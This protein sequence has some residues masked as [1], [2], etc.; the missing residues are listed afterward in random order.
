MESV[1]HSP[2][3]GVLFLFFSFPSAHS[4]TRTVFK[5]YPSY[6]D[7]PSDV[8]IALLGANTPPVSDTGA[9]RLSVALRSLLIDA[10]AICNVKY[11]DAS[12]KKF[13]AKSNEM[14]LFM[15][16][17]F[18]APTWEGEGCEKTAELTDAGQVVHRNPDAIMGKAGII[19]YSDCSS[20]VGHWD[21]WDGA[22]DRGM[23]LVRQCRTK[24]VWNVC[25]QV[26]NPD[27]SALRRFMHKS[28]AWDASSEPLDENKSIIPRK[29]TGL[30]PVGARAQVKVAQEHLNM[31]ASR[32]TNDALK[33]GAPDGV[34]SR[35]TFSA[36]RAFQTL[37]T[38]PVTGRLDD[39]TMQALAHY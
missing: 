2:R 6:L 16:A 15:R 35:A 31:L 7:Q 20:A 37:A 13:L 21:V 3:V 36:I 29:E 19:Y 34:Y 33:C 39:K 30:S 17:T 23:G 18:G 9:M 22:R 25:S 38:L 8:F 32:F 4:P 12:G 28:D 1:A 11:K 5:A 26:Q 14:E 10:G 27:Y 24:R